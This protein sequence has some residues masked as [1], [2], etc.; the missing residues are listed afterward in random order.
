MRSAKHWTR[1]NI[2]RIAEL[3]TGTTPP[4]KTAEYFDGLIN[5]YTPQDVVDQLYLG[6]SMRTITEKARQDKKA[7]F[8][9]KG[10]ILL[11]AIGN[12]GRVGILRTEAS[13]N[14]QITGITLSTDAINVEYLFYWILG[15][16]PEVYARTSKATLP[17]INQAKIK[18]IPVAYPSLAEQHRLVARIKECMEWV[19]EIEKNSRL[20][21]V[22]LRAL[23]PAFLHES[24]NEVRKAAPIKRLEDIADIKGGGSLPKGASVKSRDESVLLVKVGDMNEVGNE[25]IIQT[26]RSH[27]PLS[28]AINKVID[29]G[30]VIFPRGVELLLRTKSAF[31]VVRQ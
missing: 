15:N 14:Q 6:P 23:F 8:F 30:A 28:Q 29:S 16:R 27:I 26:S 31:L 11:T 9:K 19:E 4:S 18:E 10:T 7:R 5:W 1:T 2:G 24:F 20:I 3:A 25:R 22:E 13:A 21:N 12:V 17:I